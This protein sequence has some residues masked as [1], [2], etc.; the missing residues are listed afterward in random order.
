MGRYKV[1]ISVQK[2]FIFRK[3]KDE[4]KTNSKEWINNN[5]QKNKTK[6]KQK[7]DPIR[8]DLNKLILKSCYLF[9]LMLSNLTIIMYKAK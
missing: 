5:T 8:I 6:I 2:Q 7:I 9:Y 3:I 4:K 1:D